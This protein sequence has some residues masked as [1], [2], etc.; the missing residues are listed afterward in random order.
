M[1]G[2]SGPR[3][4]YLDANGTAMNSLV[5]SVPTT[6]IHLALENRGSTILNKNPPLTV[7]SVQ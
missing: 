3:T 6:G 4:L 2:W 5:N 7:L 1:L